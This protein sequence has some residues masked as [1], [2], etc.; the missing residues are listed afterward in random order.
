MKIDK[1]A[2]ESARQIVDQWDFSLM[3]IKMQELSHAGWDLPRIDTAIEDYK[4]Y[5]AITKS[6]NGY[7]LVPN[8]DIDRIWH[9][10]ILDTRQYAKDCQELLGG[11]LHH[12]PYF[13]MRGKSDESKWK[14]A[15][16]ISTG[17]WTEMFG[18]SLYEHRSSM[19]CPQACPSGIDS[20]VQSPI[21][22]AMK[23]PQACPSGV[24]TSI[25]YSAMKCPQACPSGIGSPIDTSYPYLQ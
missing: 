12:Y 6:L 10:H 2:Y 19:K 23:C 11:F 24:G 7:Q 18:V 1:S 13:G 25:Q 21:T 20:A 9:E 16:N 17:V 4:R 8:G 14:E 5:M 15:T 3:R 22:F